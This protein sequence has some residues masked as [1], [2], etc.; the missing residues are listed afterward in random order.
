MKVERLKEII[1][2]GKLNGE[3][4]I[5]LILENIFEYQFRTNDFF[6]FWMNN[7]KIYYIMGKKINLMIAY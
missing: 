1:I 7:L 6:I 4:K 2:I 3:T 5:I